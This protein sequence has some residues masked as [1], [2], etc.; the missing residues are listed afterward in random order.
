MPRPVHIYLFLFLS[1]SL[2]PLLQISPALTKFKNI[3]WLKTPKIPLSG[4]VKPCML[5]DL[6]ALTLRHNVILSTN[7]MSPQSET[8][9]PVN[10]SPHATETPLPGRDYQSP[11]DGRKTPDFMSRLLLF[12]LDYHWGIPWRDRSKKAPNTW[13]LCNEAAMQRAKTTHAWGNTLKQFPWNLN[14]A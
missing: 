11:V 5:N 3:F 8:M 14:S 1:Q 2:P 10:C 7:S 4:C 9:S 6:R 12:I 13:S